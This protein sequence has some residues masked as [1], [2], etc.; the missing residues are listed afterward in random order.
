MNVVISRVRKILF[1]ESGVLNKNLTIEELKK[2]TIS[3][4]PFF[5]KIILFIIILSAISRLN[6]RFL[7][8]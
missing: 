5:I 1:L 7:K 4:Q 2:E 6:E 8:L 3:Y